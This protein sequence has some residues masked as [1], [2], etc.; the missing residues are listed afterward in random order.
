MLFSTSLILPLALLCQTASSLSVPS[1]S[2]GLSLARR[3]QQD[4]KAISQPCIDKIQKKQAEV[5]EHC[6]D[7]QAQVL[8]ETD[9]QVVV[10]TFEEFIV[11]MNKCN[12]TGKDEIDLEWYKELVINVFASVQVVIEIVVGTQDQSLIEVAQ[13]VFAQFKVHVAN[14]IDLVIT[15]DVQV[16]VA[17][18]DNVDAAAYAA[19]GVD[20]VELIDGKVAGETSGKEPEKQAPVKKGDGDHTGHP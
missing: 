20:I 19:V 6:K 11:E 16:A 1:V 15:I 3:N 18:R 17:I 14:F 13:D 5:K 2:G 9:L 10:Q 4:A 8:V 12:C 7:A